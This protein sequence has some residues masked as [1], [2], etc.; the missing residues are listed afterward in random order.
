MRG[1]R[2]PRVWRKETMDSLRHPGSVRLGFSTSSSTSPIPQDSAPPDLAGGWRLRTALFLLL[3]A[4]SPAFAAIEGY[5]KDATGGAGGSV[6]TV[7]S[8]A[9]QGP[10]TWDSCVQKGGNQTIRFA[11]S[12][13]TVYRTSYLR[14]N[15]TVDGCS[16]GQNGVTLQQPADR[17]RTV[18]IQGPVSNVIVRCIRFQSTGK[19]PGYLV[20]DDLM[21]VDGTSGQVSK[22]VVDHC[23]FVD[24][25]DGAL[26]ITGNVSDLTASWNLFYGTPLTQLIKYGTRQ[27]I[28]LHH[29]VYTA[30][31]ERNPQIRG[32]AWDIDFISN[33]VYNET[34]TS[35]AVGNTF[36]PYGTRLWNAGPNTESPGNVKANLRSNFYAGANAGVQIVTD[37][38]ASAAGIYIGPD[39]VC[40]GGCPRSPTSTPT[41]VTSAYAVTATPVACMASQML[42]TVGSPNRTTA[43]QTQLDAVVAALPGGC[44]GSAYSLTVT[45]AGTGSGT[46]TSSPAGISCGADCW[47]TYAPG[48]VV[49][50]NAAAAVGSYFVG[51]SGACGGTSPC[52]VTVDAAKSVVATFNANGYALTVAHA[53]AGS[54]TVTS[55][56]TGIT[57]GTD[58]YETYTYGTLVTLTQTAAAGSAFSGWS[59]A[60]TGTGSCQVTMDAAKSV[61]ASFNVSS[62]PYTLSVT[63]DGDA[64]GSVDSS[65]YGISCGRYCSAAYPAGTLVTLYA[66][67]AS[68]ALFAGWGGACTGTA[69]SCQFTMSSS[70]SVTATFKRNLPTL[71]VMNSGPGTGTVTSAPAGIHCE[72]DCSEPYEPGTIVTL[73]ARAAHG[74]VFLGWTGGPCYGTGDCRVTMN[75]S[76]ATSAVFSISTAGGYFT[77][78]PCRVLDTRNPVGPYGG[79]AIAAGTSRVFSLV[80]RCGIPSTARAIAVNLTV[81]QPTAGGNLRLYPAD[82]PAPNASSLNYT[83]GMTRANSQVAGLSSSGALAIRC[84]QSAGTAHV[85]LD[86]TGYFE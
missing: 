20:E 19:R 50:L 10:G 36:T 49:T 61:T 2:R 65:P 79:P 57:C 25:T 41:A 33:A 4:S 14:S 43:D 5:G 3:A 9:E 71:T 42:P 47:H 7:T 53:G 11:I 32:A 44:S 34:I 75:V 72:D 48:T 78:A 8:S 23:T 83:A 70:K 84:M 38:G 67:T 81:T 56:P 46:I 60:C 18:A 51:W 35:D 85:I 15:T 66:S 29:N 28:S 21:R 16:N 77:L 40:A 55:T 26:D 54:G 22:V 73:T 17:H 37:A 64:T 62:G 30:G 13:A 82:V 58:C 74:S 86:V 63:T 1:S 39:N 59:G 69:F 68:G 31:G 12:S 45:P 24:A 52:Q 80:G 6:C 27:R 76:K